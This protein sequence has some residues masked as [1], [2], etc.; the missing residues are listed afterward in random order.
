MFSLFKPKEKEVS[1]TDNIPVDNLKNY[2]VQGYEKEKELM[3]QLE[4]KESYIKKLQQRTE[5]FDALKVVLAKK[6]TDIRLLEQ[7][8]ELVEELKDRN[9]ELQ[10]KNSTLRI[11]NNNL[12]K[13][14]NQSDE[15]MESTAKKRILD[16][17][18]DI[19]NEFSELVTNYKGNLS[20]KE[21]RD[22]LDS[23]LYVKTK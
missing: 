2:V 11:Q 18:D 5:E 16:F 1:L 20:K 21:A 23:L 3:N 4:Q 10:G 14:K 17:S 22:I 13:E 19:L 6:E 15:L 9:A 12:V 7:Q 8:L